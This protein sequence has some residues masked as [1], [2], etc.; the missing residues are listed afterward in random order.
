M[1]TRMQAESQAEKQNKGAPKGVSFFAKPEVI[2]WS[3]AEY[4]G[5]KAK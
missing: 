3:V 5:R 2:G 4:K 1:L